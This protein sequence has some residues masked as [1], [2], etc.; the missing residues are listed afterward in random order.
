MDIKIANLSLGQHVFDFLEKVEDIEL[1]EPFYGKISTKVTL[2]KLSDQIIADVSSDLSAEFECD[3]CTCKFENKITSNYQMIYMMRN[4]ESE[5]DDIN[6]TFINRE[7]DK[8]SLD[9]DVREF[10]IL[11]IPM[12]K[13]C[14]E[15][16]KGLCP[17]CGV[18][19]NFEE[20]KCQKDEI[21][22]VWL[23]LIENKDKL[24]NKKRNR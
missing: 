23:P 13:L 20:C 2:N 24:N 22:P 8:I 15:D 4:D 3:R 11:A 12:K 6:V 21:N 14:K 16:C 17:R 9:N 5:S 10:A 1:N 7:T 19:L 18:D